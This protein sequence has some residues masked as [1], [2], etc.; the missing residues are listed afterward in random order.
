MA[1]ADGDSSVEMG[2]GPPNLASSKDRR[3]ERP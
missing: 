2:D 3:Q 1:Y